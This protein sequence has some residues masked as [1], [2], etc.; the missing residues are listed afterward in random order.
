MLYLLQQPHLQIIDKW[1]EGIV[2]I[3]LIL[4]L[5]QKKILHYIYIDL[6]KIVKKNIYILY[7]IMHAQHVQARSNLAN[8][9][10]YI[11][12]TINFIIKLSKRMK[13]SFCEFQCFMLLMD[14]SLSYTTISNILLLVNCRARIIYFINSRSLSRRYKRRFCI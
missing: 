1:Q 4:L 8:I 2:I 7:I 3:M 9:L 14:A 11:F 13:K 5:F 10:L 6:A 12:Y